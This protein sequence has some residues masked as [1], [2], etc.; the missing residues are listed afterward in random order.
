MG[1][2][3]NMGKPLA[4]MLL[5][6]APTCNTYNI[7]T[8]KY[9]YSKSFSNQIVCSVGSACCQGVLSLTTAAMALAETWNIPSLAR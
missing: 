9:T 3:F 7:S 6:Q 2:I 5:F 8:H 1:I 4:R